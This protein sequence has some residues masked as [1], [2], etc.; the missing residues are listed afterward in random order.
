MNRDD[1][2]ED[3]WPEES[4]AEPEA[5][6]E[7]EE[8]DRGLYTYD[9][10][11]SEGEEGEQTAKTSPEEADFLNAEDSA[12][13]AFNEH[14]LYKMKNPPF[15]GIGKKAGQVADICIRYYIHTQCDYYFHG[16]LHYYERTINHIVNG[17]LL[18]Y[19]LGGHFEDLKQE[20]ITGILEAL[21]HYD[22]S[23]KKSFCKYANRYIENR[24]HNYTRRMRRGCTV[25]T[26]YA[27]DK[28][29]KV[30][31]LFNAYGGRSDDETISRIAK[32]AKVDRDEAGE[33]IQDALLNMQCTDIYRSYGTGDGEPEESREEI[34]VS[35]YPTP[36]QKLAV[37]YEMQ[38]LW[39]A[40]DSLTLREKDIVADRQGFC[41]ECYGVLKC[42]KPGDKWY[43][44]RPR[45]R[46]PFEDLAIDYGLSSPESAERIYKRSVRKMQKEY[47]HEFELLFPGEPLPKGLRKAE[48]DPQE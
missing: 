40:W 5:P 28:L 46:T 44:C 30:M 39:A 42:E 27:Y 48:E 20:A 19:A 25:E 2:L 47:I 10:A 16:F 1:Y 4:P 24:L 12:A 29:R 13:F 11:P 34:V 22:P 17:F 23:Q 7:E 15:S 14:R 35:S 32:A 45:K 43:D 33:L 18:R 31:A 9:T 26:D 3:E 6:A 36:Y 21:E 38:P 37:V 41:L 8:S